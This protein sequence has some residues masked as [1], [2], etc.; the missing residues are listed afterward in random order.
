[1]IDITFSIRLSTFSS[2]KP[3]S[4]IKYTRR[5]TFESKARQKNLDP[6]ILASYASK[7]GFFMYRRWAFHVPNSMHNLIY[8]PLFPSLA[9]S[10]CL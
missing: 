8:I 7:A 4:R 5:A 6:K 3:K 9:E 2:A 10:T 1:M